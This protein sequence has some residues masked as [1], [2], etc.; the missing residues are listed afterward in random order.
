ML[1]S[2]RENTSVAELAHIF[3]GYQSGDVLK[4]VSLRMCAGEVTALA[5]PNGAGKSTLIRVLTG[6]L[7]A[8]TGLVRCNK[9]ETSLVPQE[10]ALYPWLT[11]RENCVAF[12][13]MDGASR[14]D[15]GI[16]ASN[17]LD[18][19]GCTQVT[20]TRVSRLSGGYRRR[21]NIAVAL[22]SSPKLMI[23]DE[24]TAGLDADAKRV[25][26]DVM[27]RVRDAGCAILVV[28]HDFDVVEH[29]ADRIIVLAGGRILRDESPGDLMDTIF[30]GQ[31]PVELLLQDAA[32]EHQAAFLVAHGAVCYGP[33]R[34][35]VLQKRNY[36]DV[37]P[38]SDA[39]AEAGLRIVEMRVREPN[40]SD[41]YTLLVKAEA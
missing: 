24:P 27:R 30:A 3:A 28:T 38:L 36:T 4:D 13:M 35:V 31:R 32:N 11:A 10:I 1:K 5:G 16:G 33:T 6:T 25:V 37:G 34:W 18:M 17:A 40:L 22:M 26:Q 2:Q 14:R 41:A 7:L 12:S 19:A 39:M 20:D 23:L 15:A 29:L 21:V 8:R 9:T